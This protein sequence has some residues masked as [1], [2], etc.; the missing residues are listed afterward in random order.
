M[1]NER[2]IELLAVRIPEAGELVQ[3]SRAQAYALVASGEWP[4]IRV[5][6]SRRVPLDG[7]RQWI[8]REMRAGGDRTGSGDAPHTTVG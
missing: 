8:E 2:G 1:A 4:S 7:L 6:R 5:G 3:I